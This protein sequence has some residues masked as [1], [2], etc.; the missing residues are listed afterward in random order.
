VQGA[1][2]CL[3]EELSVFGFLERLASFTKGK[4]RFE[5]RGLLH[6]MVDEIAGQ[7]FGE[8]RNIVNRFLRVNLSE[9]PTCL[10][11]GINQVTAEF[12][13]SGFENSEQATWAGTNND[14]IGFNHEDSFEF[15][16]I[17]RVL[18]ALQQLKSKMVAQEMEASDNHEVES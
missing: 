10:W 16:K 9:L 3:H 6:Q 1:T 12:Q 7:Y 15:A 17:R 14:N 5:R 2:A 13:Q 18:K 8:S 4:P 11:Q